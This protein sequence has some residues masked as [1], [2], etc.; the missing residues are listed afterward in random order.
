MRTSVKR[1]TYVTIAVG[2][3]ILAIAAAT[4]TFGNENPALRIR[5]VAVH[6]KQ[7]AITVSNVSGLTQTG[8]VTSPVLRNGSKA[9]GASTVTAQVTA[10]PGES[11]TVDLPLPAAT[12]EG[13]PTGVV[14]DDGVPF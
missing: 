2:A 1:L 14:V 7:V 4:S 8:T 3:L 10:A 6:G 13:Q 11:V 9:V 12:P 5:A